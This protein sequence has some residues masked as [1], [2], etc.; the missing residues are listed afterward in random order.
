MIEE[1]LKE[2]KSEIG[3]KG[4]AVVTKDGILVKSMLS[5]DMKDEVVSAL[6]SFLIQTTEK[7]MNECSMEPFSKFIITS[8]NGKVIFVNLDYAYLVVVTDQFINIDLTLLNIMSA[9]QKL[10]RASRI[11]V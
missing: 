10:K 9:A 8:T 5:H 4:C 7:A 1:I 3:V 6:S 2:L 11:D